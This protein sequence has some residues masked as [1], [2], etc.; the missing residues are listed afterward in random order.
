MYSTIGFIIFKYTILFS[1]SQ[2]LY[3]TKSRFFEKN[4]KIFKDFLK[5]FPYATNKNLYATNGAYAKRNKQKR[6]QHFCATVFNAFFALGANYTGRL[7]APVRIASV[8]P[9]RD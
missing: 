5:I 4:H 7:T 2:Y 9:K 3:A 6:P 8:M 1:P